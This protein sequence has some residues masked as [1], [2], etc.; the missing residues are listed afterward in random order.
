MAQMNMIQALNSAMDIMLGRDPNVVIIGQDI[1][2]FGGVFRATDG[3]QREYGET[4]FNNAREAV[5]A[6]SALAQSTFAE[7]RDAFQSAY[8]TEEVAVEAK[9]RTKAKKAA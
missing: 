7:A 6:Q 3:L 8:S 1:G 5:E 4:L 2:Y 9:P